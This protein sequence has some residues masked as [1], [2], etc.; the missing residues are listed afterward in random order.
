MRG[1]LLHARPFQEHGLL[2]DW[3]TD[4]RG[5]VRM[6]QTGGRR[7]RKRGSSRPPNFVCLDL[8]TAGRG[9]GWPILKG[10]EAVEPLRFLRGRRL[11]AAFYLHELILRALRPEEPVPGLFLDY[12]KSLAMLEEPDMPVSVIMRRFE[13]RLL[14]HLGSGVEWI[15]S[16]AD[17]RAD[18]RIDP[19][20]SYRLGPEGEVVA[21]G[22]SGTVSGRVLQAIATDQ[23]LA[24]PEERR[25]AR[26]LMQRLLVPHVGRAPFVSRRL[27]P[28]SGTP[29]SGETGNASEPESP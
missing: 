8:L 9:S 25:A 24:Q 3:L 27:W 7:V 17:N 28:S 6:R 23:V 12:W 21:A 20:G 15:E 19:E 22:G 1:F 29:P 5:W 4:D 14:I 10:A 16:L 13:R 26:D 11:A 2:L 18:T